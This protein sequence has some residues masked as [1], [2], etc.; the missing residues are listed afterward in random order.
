MMQQNFFGVAETHQ[1]TGN[2]YLFLMLHIAYQKNPS[3][4]IDTQNARCWGRQTGKVLPYFFFRKVNQVLTLWLSNQSFGKTKCWCWQCTN[5]ISHEI[6]VLTFQQKNTKDRQTIF[7]VL[8]FHLEICFSRQ[9]LVV[10]SSCF[11]T[12]LRGLQDR[13][14]PCKQSLHLE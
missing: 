14:M 9:I 2:A 13:E 11:L 5:S 10:A 12:W 6:L 1:N 3:F 8:P 4:L 7:L